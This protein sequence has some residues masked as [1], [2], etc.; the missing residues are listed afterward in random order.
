MM[1]SEI[2]LESEPGRGSK[3]SFTINIRWLDDDEAAAEPEKTELNLSG[4]RVLVVED[5]KLN[6]E[7][8]HLLL[9]KYGLDVD[10]AENGEEALRKVESSEEG[11]YDL[12]LMDI[13]MPVMDGLEATKEIRK[14]PRE[15]CRTV[16]IIAMS[17]NAFDEDVKRS[18]ASGMNAHLSKPVNVKKLEETLG[19]IMKK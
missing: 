19:A 13:M 17:A 2:E 16:P 14:I 11:Y 9:E 4:K 5:N 15:D 1:N 10:E 12:I 6:M 3:F 7:I 18:I 8:I